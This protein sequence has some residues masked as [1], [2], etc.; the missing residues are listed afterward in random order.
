MTENNGLMAN[1]IDALA[2]ARQ[3]REASGEV[4]GVEGSLPRPDDLDITGQTFIWTWNVSPEITVRST[5]QGGLA[6][7]DPEQWKVVLTMKSG[8]FMTMTPDDSKNLGEALLSTNE[9]KIV[10]RLFFVDYFMKNVSA[11]AQAPLV[12]VAARDGYGIEDVEV[13]VIDGFSI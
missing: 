10:W 13:E 6:D 1:L 12:D 3:N 8:N 11:N 5:Y 9:W 7:D 2:N 4:G